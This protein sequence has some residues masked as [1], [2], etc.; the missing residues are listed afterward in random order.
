MTPELIAAL[1]RTKMSDREAVFTIA[2]AAR[3]L[4][5]DIND[6]TL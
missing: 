4:G 6:L 5:H 3:S 1:D 2:A